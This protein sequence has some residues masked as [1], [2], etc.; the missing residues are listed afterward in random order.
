MPTGSGRVSAFPGASP[1]SYQLA[2]RT[3]GFERHPWRSRSA[4]PGAPPTAHQD[5]ASGLLLADAHARS[6]QGIDIEGLQVRLPQLGPLE[7]RLFEKGLFQMGL[8]EVSL[9]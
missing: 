1:V 6:P 2:R 4:A 8:N 5:L 7:M 3:V 9:L